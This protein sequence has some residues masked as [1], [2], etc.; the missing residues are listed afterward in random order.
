MTAAK[1][2]DWVN[3]VL[4]RYDISIRKACALIGLSPRVFYYCALPKNDRAIKT[5]LLQLAK[6]HLRWGF[7]KMFKYLRRLG[8]RWNHKRVYRVYC[9][10]KLNLRKKP[11]KRLPPRDSIPLVQPMCANQTWSLDFMHDVLT[12]GRCFR[13]FNILDDFNRQAL[14]IDIAFS[15]PARRV[16]DVLD[17]LIAVQGQPKQIRSDNGCEFTSHHYQNWAKE[18][19]IQLLFIQPGKP[20]QNAYIER[21]N[22]TYRED[23]LDAYWFESLNEV[24]HLTDQWLKD[25]NYKRPHQAL[26]DKTPMQFLQQ[27]A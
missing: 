23:I 25:Y 17:M 1:R 22:R 8:H 20:A 5:L 7:D 15:M 3:T 2:R 13:T 21:F 26:N 14:H 16:T 19:G 18:N 12:N 10:L 6:A 9:D 24:T 11:K 27:A 4:S